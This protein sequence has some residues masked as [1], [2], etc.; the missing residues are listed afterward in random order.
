MSV[1]HDELDLHTAASETPVVEPAGDALLEVPLTMPLDQM[2]SQI[3]ADSVIEAAEYAAAFLV[4]GG[5]E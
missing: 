2:L 1:L 5:G 3:S 4:P